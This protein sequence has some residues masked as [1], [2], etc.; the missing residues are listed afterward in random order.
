[1]VRKILIKIIGARIVDIEILKKMPLSI[2]ISYLNERIIM[3]LRGMIFLRKICFL[4]R[5]V[6]FKCKKRIKIGRFVTIHDY[7]Y[8]DAS[9]EKGIEIEDYC[10]IGRNTYVRS[11]NLAS[12]DG[13][14]IMRKGSSCNF[15]CF[16]GATGGIEIGQNVMIGPS[17]TILSE[18]HNFGSID[19][20]IKEQGITKAPVKV[21]DNVWIGANSVILGGTTIKKGAI[22]GAGSI[23]AKSV[24]SIE[25]VAGN[26]AR[27]IKN[28]NENINL[29]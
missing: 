29:A 28:R 15:N 17:I 11:G 6:S 25:I 14:F 27:V 22:I 8:I 4:G 9:S 20:D 13:Y 10:T 5:G 2:L 26:P 19:T 1:M 16:L 23:V 24:N 21:E 12:Y 3:L 7:S 18:K